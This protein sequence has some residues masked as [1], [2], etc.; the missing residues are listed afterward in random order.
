MKM[1]NQELLNFVGRIKLPPEKKAACIR[2]V[3]A[4]KAKVDEAIR[5]MPSAKVIKVIQAGSLKKGTALKPWGDNPLDADMVFFVGVDDRTKFDAEELRRE[6]ISVLRKAYPGKQ[7]DDFANGK[8]TVGVVFKGSGLEVDIVPF[9]PD[10]RNSDYGRQPRKKLRSGEF[11]TSVQG[12]LDFIIAAKSRWSSFAP[13]VRMVKWWRNRKEL[14]LPSFAVELLFAHLL[15]IRRLGADS[16]IEP[17]LAE[18]FEFVSANPKMRVGF[19]GAIGD[20][21]GGAPIVADPTNNANNV[22]GN[23]SPAEWD[24]VVR[25]ANTAFER[26]H[27]ARVIDGKTR[28]VDIWREVFEG[29]NIQEA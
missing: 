17:A 5:G 25:K 12:Q 11:R 2:Q 7:S 6:I 23:I 13:A 20:L 14:E 4:L 10:R 8:K 26:I 27:H 16:G 28:T 3:D 21:S 1:T 9:I 15:G 18:F 29:F 24:E 22:L 19:P